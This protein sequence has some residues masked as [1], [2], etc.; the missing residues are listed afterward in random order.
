MSLTLV[1]KTYINKENSH[2]FSPLYLHN[3]LRSLKE[4]VLGKQQGVSHLQVLR[5]RSQ[6]GVIG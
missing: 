5:L 1:F 4:N 2:G 6:R 3:Q